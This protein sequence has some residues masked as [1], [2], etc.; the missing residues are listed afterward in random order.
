MIHRPQPEGL[1]IERTDGGGFVVR[2][3]AAERAVALSDLTNLE[4]LSY[5]Q[6]RLHK[7]GV[8]KAL[9]KAGAKDGDL[10]EIGRFAFEYSA[11]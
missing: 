4:A 8:D 11:D 9:A 7:L 2:G 1:V 10:V 3:K 5:V 6:E